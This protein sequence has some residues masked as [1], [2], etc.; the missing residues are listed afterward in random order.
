[1]RIRLEIDPF[2][3]AVLMVVVVWLLVMLARHLK[4][5]TRALGIAIE[6]VLM[7]N[8]TLKMGAIY[9]IALVPLLNGNPDGEAKLNGDASYEGS[10]PL[11][12]QLTSDTVVSDGTTAPA[13]TWVLDLSS[14]SDGQTGPIS[15]KA[16]YTWADD[17]TGDVSF[18]ATFLVGAVSSNKHD[19]GMTIGGVGPDA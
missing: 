6:G 15:A 12:R 16:N 8:F 7:K 5:P 11:V 9:V 17:F 4:Q 1:M 3:I 18:T 13:G 2:E 19:L 10:D 14:S